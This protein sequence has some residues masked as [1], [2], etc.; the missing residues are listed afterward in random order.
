MMCVVLRVERGASSE[1]LNA[2]AVD[3]T[4]PTGGDSHLAREVRGPF[5]RANWDPPP[6]GD[7]GGRNTNLLTIVDR[8]SI[9]HYRGD[10]DR[11]RSTSTGIGRSTFV[12]ELV[13]DRLT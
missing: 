3:G 5:P 8:P 12:D 7:G 13:V 9:D 4:T 1:T 10:R 11:P 6:V 2:E